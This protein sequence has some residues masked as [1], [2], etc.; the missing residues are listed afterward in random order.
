M[1][2]LEACSKP[3]IAAVHGACVG[4][5][6]DL[7]AAADVRL[8]SSDATFC[9]KEVD[10]AITADLGTLQRLPR[11]VGDG[12]AREWA[13]TARTFGAD[14]AERAGLVATVHDDAAALHAAAERLAGELALKPAAA[15]VGS[16]RALLYA[17]GR[18]VA[19][20]LEQ[21]A[22][23]NAGMLLSDDLLAVVRA[24]RAR[25]KL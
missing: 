24:V 18:P 4:G 15:L 16:K 21:V 8:C 10:L 1:S 17:R 14:E 11:I 20:S 23:W 13:L 2:A 19:D 6:V 7:I 9:V 22:L 25:A 5:G 3:V 12:R